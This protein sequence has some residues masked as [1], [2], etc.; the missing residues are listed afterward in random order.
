MSDY[1]TI[2]QI[3]Q[4][5]L[6]K[7]ALIEASAGTGKTY[8]IEHLV[9]E[10]LKQQKVEDI[11][12]ILVVTFTEA[13]TNELKRRIYKIIQEEYHKNPLNHIL[14]KALQNFD[15]ISIN[16]IHGFCYTV[17]KTF[18]FE[19]QKVF[20]YD[21]VDDNALYGKLLKEQ[22]RSRWLKQYGAQLKDYFCITEIDK[23]EKKI[24]EIVKHFNANVGDV[25]FPD[26]DEN[27]CID[28]AINQLI[29]LKMNELCQSIN[30]NTVEQL[31]QKELYQRYKEV[32]DIA[33]TRRTYDLKLSNME[34][35]IHFLEK[36]L[37]DKVTLADFMH[38]RKSLPSDNFKK[39]LQN[40]TTFFINS[41]ANKQVLAPEIEKIKEGLIDLDSRL[42]ISLSQS[43][44]VNHWKD[45]LILQATHQFILR[46]VI[47]LKKDLKNY[48]IEKGSIS[49]DDML[50]FVGEAL[51]KEPTGQWLLSSLRQQFKY[52][53][54]DEFQDTDSIQWG[55]FSKVFLNSLK[56]KLFLIGDPKQSIYAFRGADIHTYIKAKADML[57]LKKQG[58][59]EIYYLAVNYRSLP[60]LIE[61]FNQL[62]TVSIS[63]KNIKEKLPYFNQPEIPYQK[64]ESPEENKRIS[65]IYSDHKDRNLINIVDFTTEG[66]LTAANVRALNAK[67]I[68]EEIDRLLNNPSY[69][70][71]IADK[72]TGKAR[73]LY[74]N[75]ICILFKI[76][77]D[78]IP[79]EEELQRCN[80]PYLINKKAGIY[81]SKEALHLSYLLEAIAYP[82]D[83]SLFKKALLTDFFKIPIQMLEKYSDIPPDHPI[84]LLFEQWETMVLQRKFP[85]LFQSI[86]ED[87]GL[88]Y[89]K[90]E[91][92]HTDWETALSNYNQI[93]QNLLCKSSQEN[94]DFQDIVDTLNNYIHRTVDIE[95]DE[96]LYN[97]PSEQNK[98]RIISMHLSKGLEFPVVFLAGGFTK[99]RQTPY[100]YAYDTVSA[101]KI[102]DITKEAYKE[103]ADQDEDQENRRLYYVSITRATHKLYLPFTT[104]QSVSAPIKE[105]LY[106]AIHQCWGGGADNK[107]VVHLDLNGNKINKNSQFST[108]F[109]REAMAQETIDQ[110]QDTSEDLLKKIKDYL[111]PKD[112]SFCQNKISLT[113]FSKLKDSIPKVKDAQPVTLLE[114]Q[115]YHYGDD[116]VPIIKKDDDLIIEKDSVQEEKEEVSRQI[117]GIPPGPHTGTLLH[118]LLEEI[119]Y[120]KV[121]KTKS[122]NE[123]LKK[124]DIE[125]LILDKMETYNL[126]QYVKPQE[127]EKHRTHYKKEITQI[128]WNT[129]KTP[130]GKENIVLCDL[131]AEDRKH[132]LEFYLPLERLDTAL[133]PDIHIN[134]DGY[135]N[136]IIDLVFRYKE[137]YYIVDWKSNYIEEGYDED[138]LR[139]NMNVNHYHLQYILYLQ[140]LKQWLFSNH[141]VGD[142]KEA[143]QSI[144]GIYY[145]YLRGI[146]LDKKGYGIFQ[147]DH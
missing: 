119:D 9:V 112:Y 64:S 38:L 35:I 22:M 43:K 121:S 89:S 54:I 84:K 24:L 109:D 99:G 56:Q 81:Q 87:T 5:D 132:E 61:S 20:Q 137:K 138:S 32:I 25:L 140:A 57:Q 31:K 108:V 134:E 18:S 42:P 52:A 73:K 136:G 70:I 116:E 103:K 100:I 15:S 126:L 142:L 86:M 12:E 83:E 62:F 10:L 37:T 97:K 4:I 127:K 143:S 79:I 36:H 21:I 146:T 124:A 1:K 78:R 41:V 106:P 123:L 135:L 47:Q 45:N 110:A 65:R 8:T 125:K 13:S 94:L 6:D 34:E 114:Q 128:I 93:M 120:A 63:K 69:T 113:S 23:Y 72:T 90:L 27:Y 50:Y 33:S 74:P 29:T 7:H 101:R 122:Y 68:A 49:Y 53:F 3:D 28:Q 88:L 19:N 91:N 104:K 102:I 44:K 2:H 16:T 129:L 130:I 77:S 46:S 111:S 17:L 139:K 95:E 30:I 133:V 58:K 66:K 92:D 67:F 118:E 96:D 59:A 71:R 48:K 115:N 11:S 51:Q 105:I 82:F 141:V 147:A 145:I 40:L 85:L 144:G 39:D 55:I 60:G 107:H 14:K 117:M 76:K 26:Y 75:D 131:R 80:I 98:V